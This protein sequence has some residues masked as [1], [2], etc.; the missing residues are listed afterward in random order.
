MKARIQYGGSV[1]HGRWQAPPPPPRLRCAAQ[2]RH[3]LNPADSLLAC[4]ALCCC[5]NSSRRHRQARGAQAQA[6]QRRA[7]RGRSGAERREQKAEERSAGHGPHACMAG[8]G[9][10]RRCRG[11]FCGAG[12]RRRQPGPCPPAGRRSGPHCG[13]RSGERV[14][15]RAAA[16]GRGAA[17]RARQPCDAKQGG[18]A[19]N[20]HCAFQGAGISQMPLRCSQER[21]GGQ[22]RSR[23]DGCRQ[24]ADCRGSEDAEVSNIS[25]R[26]GDAEAGQ[27]AAADPTLQL[28]A[29]S[30][31]AAGTAA[32]ARP[33]GSSRPLQGTAAGAHSAGRAQRR[34]PLPPA[35]HSEHPS[36]RARSPQRSAG[37]SNKQGGRA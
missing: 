11:R 10:L 15:V 3:D 25:S 21:R 31:A 20:A 22:R 13:Q 29:T 8:H 27:Q 14:R 37:C 5:Y 26:G 35:R 16:A 32:A 23:L 34:R 2:P 30:A 24:R 6:P 28:R 36:C 12:W 7:A 9:R 33:P 4:I 1:R 19:G 17:A 18:G